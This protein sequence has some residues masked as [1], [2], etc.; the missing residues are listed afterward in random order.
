[1]Q[2]R[3]LHRTAVTIDF[4]AFGDKPAHSASDVG[5]FARRCSP[6]KTLNYLFVFQ[7][8]NLNDL[9]D[10]G[11]YPRGVAQVGVGDEPHFIRQRPGPL[12]PES[13]QAVAL[14]HI[15]RDFP[16]AEAGGKGTTH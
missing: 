9:L 13:E 4:I 16:Y 6:G 12:R 3:G 5:R 11:P 15:H 1:M 2:D 14:A 10:H 8:K 7:R